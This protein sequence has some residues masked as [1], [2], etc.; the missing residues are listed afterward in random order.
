MTLPR[1]YFTRASAWSGPLLTE[2]SS[3]PTLSNDNGS[4]D[5][6]M[7]TQGSAKAV[8]LRSKLSLLPRVTFDEEGPGGGDTSKIPI[9]MAIPVICFVGIALLIVGVRI[10]RKNKLHRAFRRAER[11]DAAPDQ[12]RF[13]VDAPTVTPFPPP[14]VAGAVPVNYNV[15]LLPIPN[16]AHH[17]PQYSSYLNL[18]YTRAQSLGQSRNPLLHTHSHSISSDPHDTHTDHGQIGYEV[19]PN[20]NARNGVRNGFMN[21]RGMARVDSVTG[22]RLPPLTYLSEVEAFR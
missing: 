19:R 17:H 16:S 5:H 15:N 4:L 8:E 18:P 9:Y 21:E 10:Y 3:I 11:T 2:T 1:S 14:A 20:F 7:A 12:S 22:V 6:Q 13:E